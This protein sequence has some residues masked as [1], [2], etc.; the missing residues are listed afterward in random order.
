MLAMGHK[1]G[2]NEGLHAGLNMLA[3]VDERNG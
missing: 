1:N 3:A 2:G